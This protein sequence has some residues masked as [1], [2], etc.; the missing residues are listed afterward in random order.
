M[1]KMQRNIRKTIC[2]TFMVLTILC[3]FSINS[4]AADAGKWVSEGNNWKYQLEDGSYV[5]NT[6]RMI[7]GYKYYFD[8]AGVMA[9]GWIYVGTRTSSDGKVYKNWYYTSAGG[10]I[11][12]GW[13]LIDGVWYYFYLDG[14]MAA[15][16]VVDNGKYYVNSKGAY[17]GKAGTWQKNA[18][19]WW[20]ESADTDRFWSL[21]Y[22][23]YVN[24]PS[25][26]VVLIEGKYYGFDRNGY[27]VR[28][29]YDFGW[30]SNGQ[31]IYV[32]YYFN[33]DGSGA[34]GW[35]QINGKWY[36]FENGYMFSDTVVEGKYYVGPNGAY[37]KTIPQA[38]RTN[39]AWKQNS[40]G[41][42][43]RYADGTYPKNERAKINGAWYYFDGNGY[44]KTGWI[45]VDGVWY[46]HIPTG[47]AAIGWYKVDD[48]WYYFGED[49]AMYKNTIVDGYYLNNSGA[50]TGEIAP[51]TAIDVK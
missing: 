7:D 14:K 10:K 44:M 51:T 30:S 37:V 32:W 21:K 49:G 47:S 45:K 25:N 34:D 2:M 16:A 17:V 50:C 48:I 43:Y 5:K 18:K 9:K 13:R 24:Y 29:W 23:R 19:G 26:D 22:G 20:Y 38:N 28:G 42:W 12:T 36:Y 33:R 35:Q 11:L 40:I 1:K 4:K 39:G 31:H 46:Y 41:Y 27:M 6:F 15:D 3:S 8:S